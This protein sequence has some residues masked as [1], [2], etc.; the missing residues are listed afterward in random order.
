MS[1]S[2]VSKVRKFDEWSFMKMALQFVKEEHE[3]R[4]RGTWRREAQYSRARL[5]HVVSEGQ[6][7]V[8]EAARGGQGLE[9]WLGKLN[10]IQKE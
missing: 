1:W 5:E 9:L 6:W 10:F 8:V 2:R 3:E 7:Q 4:T